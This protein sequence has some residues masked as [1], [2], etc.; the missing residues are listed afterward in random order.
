MNVIKF[1]V[2]FV[3]KFMRTRSS[4][5]FLAYIN[6]KNLGE[7]VEFTVD[8][9]RFNMDPRTY[10]GAIMYTTGEY[11]PCSLRIMKKFLQKGNTAIDVGASNGVLTL[12]MAKSVG[13]TGSVI[14]FEPSVF[15][16]KQLEKNIGIN[17]FKNI[18]IENR[19]LYEDTRY[20]NITD[21]GFARIDKKHFLPQQYITHFIS[22]D[23][24]VQE[25]GI[26][27]IDFIKI[28]TDGFELKI[29]QGAEKTLKR[30][31]PILLIEMRDKF[32]EPLVL[33]LS[34]I[35]YKFYREDT[36]EEYVSEE[37][38]IDDVLNVVRNVLCIYE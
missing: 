24:Y 14:A 7:E 27:K 25:K 33:L 12:R 21:T 11:E 31:K 37:E 10:I 16:F 19:G 22:L 1:A 17:N 9:I 13:E 15:R 38:V 26:K 23:A 30:D 36:L 3:P 28:D 8:D 18:T 5:L 35:G 4:R 34:K 29:I 2:K 20:E 32:S 6:H